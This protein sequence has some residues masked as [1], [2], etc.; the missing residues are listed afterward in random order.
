MADTL[1]AHGIEQNLEYDPITIEEEVA[2]AQKLVKDNPAEAKRVAYSAVKEDNLLNNAVRLAYQAQM[3]AEGNWNEAAK[4]ANRII[5]ENTRMGQE[6]VV[7]KGFISE[8]SPMKYVKQLIGAKMEAAG[9]KMGRGKKGS[10]VKKV[11][12]RVK[13]EV[14]AAKKKM[15]AAQMNIA[16]A[17]AFIESLKC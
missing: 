17:Q 14:A 6:I 13:T 9:T 8:H 2:K 12:A 10:G 4:M 1:K 11:T 7:N 3:V 5:S 16:N 15:S